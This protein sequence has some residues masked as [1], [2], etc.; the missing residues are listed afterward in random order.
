MIYLPAE[1]KDRI[2]S[3]LSSRDLKTLRIAS[4]EFRCSASRELF[5][6][7][8]TLVLGGGRD[9]ERGFDCGPEYN[10]REFLHRKPVEFCRL[11]TYLSSLLPIAHYFTVLEY[12]PILWDK[13]LLSVRIGN[14]S[15]EENEGFSYSFPYTLRDWQVENGFNSDFELESDT[16]EDD[17]DDDQNE[18]ETGGQNEGFS[19]IPEADIWVDKPYV[20]PSRYTTN[21]DRV[22]AAAALAQLVAEQDANFKDSMEALKA[23][24]LALPPLR[25]VTIGWWRSRCHR[26]KKVDFIRC[27]KGSPTG[28]LR[29]SYTTMMRRGERDAWRHYQTLI[30]I[31]QDAKQQPSEICLDIFPAY[32]FL[33]TNMPPALLTSSKYV[34]GSLQRLR[35]N[36]THGAKLLSSMNGNPAAGT[37]YELLD[38]CKDTLKALVLDFVVVGPFPNSGIKDLNC[39]LGGD[40]VKPIIFPKLEELLVMNAMIPA[41][42]VE[43][44]IKSHKNLRCLCLFQV[45]MYARAYN[46]EKLF[47]DVINPSKIERLHLSGVWSGLG[48]I[49]DPEKSH[50]GDFSDGGFQPSSDPAP[51]GWKKARINAFQQVPSATALIR[52]GSNLKLFNSREYPLFV[53]RRMYHWFEDDAIYGS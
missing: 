35:L 7:R 44:L 14:H 5:G 19:G 30:P 25:R 3:R 8:S 34:M 17:D 11:N 4:R 9:D 51:D 23:I 41:T 42:D 24:I 32:P 47:S 26:L 48:N 37:L 2:T 29:E 15:G 18:S 36:F 31:L 10:G 12:A 46:W 38:R 21:V 1:L 13:D 52:N 22:E 40:K 27:V 39:I 6:K 45:Y 50:I 49:I 20:A 28:K 43:R 33:G 53:L 16:G